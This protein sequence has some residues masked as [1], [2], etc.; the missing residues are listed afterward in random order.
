M[1][2]IKEVGIEFCGDGSPFST[3]F[4]S[5]ETLNIENMSCWE[6]WSWFNVPNEEDAG[7]FPNL[8]ELTVRNCPNLV[9]KLPTFLP[10]LGKLKIQHCPQLAKLPEML[11]SLSEL[12]I[13]NCQEMILRSLPDLTCLMTLKIK[14]ISGLISLLPFI[15]ALE[16][17]E[18]LKIA[19]CSELMYL[20]Q[21]G[22]HTEKL[23]CLKNLEIFYCEK[24]VSLLEEEGGN[25]P[26]NLE[27]LS[28][29][30]CH[31]LKNLPTGLHSLAA[32][33]DLRIYGCSNLVSLPATSLPHNL[34]VL[35][36]KYC[37]NLDN[38]PNGLQSLTSLKDLHIS[39]CPKLVSFPATGLPYSLKNLEIRN[40]ECLKSLPNGVMEDNNY[41]NETSQLERF[42]IEGCL[43]LSSFSTGK[44]SDSLKSLSIRNCPT[45]LLRS[46]GNGLS[47]LTELSIIDCPELE[48]FPLMGMSIPTLINF[49]IY[50]CENFRCLPNQMQNLVSLQSLEIYDCHGLVSFPEE[51]LSPN[52]TRL[53]I[54]D[55][56]KLTQPISQWGLH[57]LTFLKELTVRNTCPST[58]LEV[59]SPDEDGLLLPISLTDLCICGFKNLKSIS[60][61]LQSLISLQT[62]CIDSCPK[63]QS[64]P[65]EG[66]PARLGSLDIRSCPLLKDQCLKGKGDYWPIISHIPRLDIR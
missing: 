39:S 9:G 62:L 28:I 30:V 66:L 57:R 12:N 11:P 37:D 42:D 46:L 52:L 38:L 20:W 18:D 22:T 29:K 34:E 48:S 55:C 15:H 43:S 59:S 4:A 51:G 33:K 47:H 3:T 32:L 19:D 49:R 5:L 24:L 40:C 60:R 6:Q 16:A 36:I 8:R 17:L 31:N 1:A 65:M 61:G 14:R 50:S 7:N 10:S 54:W 26:H 13:E 23:A 53:M 2:G 64:L 27:G 63:L 56:Q 21:A 58:D 35:R 41:S 44:F 25:L 45:Q